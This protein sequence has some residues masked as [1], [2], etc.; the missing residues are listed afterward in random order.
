MTDPKTIL[1]VPVP[2]TANQ[3][4][5]LIGTISSAHQ[6]FCITSDRCGCDELETYLADV[7]KAHDID[8]YD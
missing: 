1:E 4:K 8:P 5:D 2:L 7:L 6:E 3:I